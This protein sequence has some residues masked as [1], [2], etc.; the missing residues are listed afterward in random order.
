MYQPLVTIV[1]PVY[2]G[3]NYLAESINSA[4]EQTYKNKEIIVVNDGS[5]DNGESEKVALSFGDKITYLSKQNGGVSSALNLCIEKMHGEWLSWLSHDDLYY[6]DKVE[7]E[8]NYV[9]KLLEKNPELDLNR[10]VVRCAAESMDKNGKTILK[11]NYSDVKEKEPLIEMI[12]NNV[13]NYRLAGC[14]FLL[15][16]DAFKKVGKFNEAIRTVSDAEY[17]YRLLFAGYD[18]YYLDR[19]LIRG[20]VHKKQVGKTKVTTFDIEGN[21]LHRWIADQMWLNEEYR[22]GKYFLRLGGYLRKRLMP[23]ASKYAFGY[24]KKLCNPVHYYIVSTWYKIWF[25][26]IGKGRNFIR[27]VYRKLKVK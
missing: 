8:V 20:R 22:Q 4:L 15:P 21:N 27:T 13:Y 9:G 6:P 2:N 7:A 18:F 25:T 1:I 11:Y 3:A 14:S 12:L 16:A 17:W 23:D 19:C 24:A 5:N 10:V 26:L